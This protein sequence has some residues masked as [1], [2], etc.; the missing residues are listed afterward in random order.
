MNKWYG[1]KFNFRWPHE[2]FCLGISIDFYDWEEIHPWSSIVLRILFFT[3][4]LDIGEGEEEK[5]TY[6]DQLFNNPYE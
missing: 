3:V 2:G 5:Q 6:N 1:L 4:V